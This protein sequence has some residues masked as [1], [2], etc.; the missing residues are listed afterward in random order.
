MQIPSVLKQQGIN[1]TT[2]VFGKLLNN[3]DA[4]CGKN[5]NGDIMRP[6]DR[7]MTLCSDSSF[8]NDT[9]GI[10]GTEQRVVPG[11][12]TAVLGNASIDFV[13][14]AAG[15]GERFFLYL[16]PHAPH[17]ADGTF[18]FTCQPAPWYANASLPSMQAPRTPAWDVSS[19]D[20]HW[21]FEQ[22]PPMDEASVAW[23]DRAFR[24]RWRALL[25]V[26][27]VVDALHAE[28]GRLGVLDTTAILFTSDQ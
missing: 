21:L 3:H 1:V 9:Y 16:A 8:F 4:F 10:D 13:R 17:I 12:Q 2:G 14:Q 11:Y 7:S 24:Q 19:P 28:L 20:K 18:D 5:L 22:Q 27:D 25:S 6:W 15:R 23:T 26:D